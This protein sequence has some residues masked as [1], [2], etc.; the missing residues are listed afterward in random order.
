LFAKICCQF[1]DIHEMKMHPRI[2]TYRRHVKKYSLNILKDESGRQVW[3]MIV[4]LL[5]GASLA[6]AIPNFLECWEMNASWRCLIWIPKA[7]AI[8]F[9]VVAVLYIFGKI[10][11][12]L[13]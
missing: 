4:V 6:I 9:G 11:S 5:V 8:V 1:E 3:G 10:G 12:K 2:R 7:T 13:G